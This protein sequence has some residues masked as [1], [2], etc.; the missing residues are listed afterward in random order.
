ML[1][2]ILLAG[3]LFSQRKELV[4][5]AIKYGAYVNGFLLGVFLISD[6]TELVLIKWE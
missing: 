2:L 3:V 4:A 1:S 6:E 5:E